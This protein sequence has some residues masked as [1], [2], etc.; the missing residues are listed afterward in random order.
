[1]VILGHALLTRSPCSQEVGQPRAS[2]GLLGSTGPG[3]ERGSKEPSSRLGVLQAVPYK[4]RSIA[5]LP[6]LKNT[7]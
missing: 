3:P 7:G 2:A 5:H 4:V 6:E 1:L